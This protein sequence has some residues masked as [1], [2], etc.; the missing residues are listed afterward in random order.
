MKKTL[1]ILTLFTPSFLFAQET[2][3]YCNQENYTFHIS[4]NQYFIFFEKEPKET[5]ERG[6]KKFTKVSDSTA[7][8]TLEE[9]ALDFNTGKST[10]TKRLNNELRSTEPVLVCEDGTLQV[11]SGQLIVKLKNKNLLNDVLGDWSFVS[12]PDKFVAN[13]YLVKIKNIST[14][15]LFSVVTQLAGYKDVEFAEPNFITFSKLY[16]NDDHYASQ[17]AINNAGYMGG[18]PDADMD[19]DDAWLLSTGQSI[20]IAIV[21]VGVDLTHTDITTNLWSTGYDATGYNPDGRPD[22]NDAH[23]TACAGIAAAVA[24]NDEGIAGVAY[25]SKIIPVRIGYSDANGLW[26]TT[27]SWKSSG[28]NWAVNNGADIISCSWGGGSSSTAIN[29]AIDNAITNG[30]V[31]N[32]VKKGCLV[33]F[34]TG[35]DNSSVSYPATRSNVIAV[36]ASSTCDQ[37]KN[38]LSCD[39]E[40]WGSNFGSELDIVAP[41][42]KVYTTDIHGSAGYVSGDYRADFNGTSA[43]CPNAAGVA[44]LILAANPNLTYTQARQILESKTDKPTG[45]TYAASSS[46][47][48]NGTWNTEVG[49][50]R[51]NANKAVIAAVGSNAITGGTNLLCTTNAAYTLTNPPSGTSITWQAT[52]SYLFAVSSGTGTT[53]N[54]SAASATVSGQGTITFYVTGTSATISR[55]FWVGLPSSYFSGSYNSSQGTFTFSLPY[56]SGV[57]TQWVVD[58]VASTCT[59]FN[60]VV[61]APACGGSPYITY[62]IFEI[63]LTATNSCGPSTSCQKFKFTCVPSKTFASLGACGGGGDPEFAAISGSADNSGIDVYPNPVSDELLVMNNYPDFVTGLNATLE[64]EVEISLFNSNQERV[65]YSKSVE[66]MNIIPVKKLPEGLYYLNVANKDG[67]LQRQINIVH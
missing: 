40:S 38:P 65:F 12:I 13:Q 18:T 9:N 52:P 24:N 41:G 3:T 63:S 46:A 54:L 26:T 33:L 36:G 58:G 62:Y 50:G 60:C 32:G 43:A 31:V 2:L 66:R 39:G 42:V 11:C 15:Q 64:R 17:W 23:G 6:I 20:K 8:I 22:F 61:P 47:H 44:A 27:N 5:V 16:T 7:L 21:D 49:Y 25:N 1:I 4:K 48:P 67:I 30:R 34:A 28:I 19:V 35:N 53:A 10:V 55:T 51:L 14:A 56:I 29:N 45:Y 59:G 37:R 57:T